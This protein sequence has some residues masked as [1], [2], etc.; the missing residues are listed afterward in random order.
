MHNFQKVIF[1]FAIAGL[2]LA[3]DMI[4]AP[5]TAPNPQS[6]ATIVAGT[7]QAITAA[8]PANT[9][10]TAAT[11]KPATQGTSISFNNVSFV[12]PQGLANGTTNSTTTD[13][14][15]P[16]INPSIGAMPQHI[17]VVFN[18]YSIHGT[19]LDPQIA[20]FK[21][22]EYAQYTDLT[23]QI[24]STLHNL[25]YVQGQPLPQGLPVGPFNAQVK[26]IDFTNGHGL[27]YL[28]QFDE[29]PLPVNNHELIYYYQGLTTDGQ[30][31][32]QVILPLQA[33][34]LPPDENPNSSL[35]ASGI[36]FN[37]DQLQSYFSA[38]TQRLNT[39]TPDQFS[40]PLTALDELIQSIE[41]KP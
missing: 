22:A 34:F 4:P 36:P 6:I 32:V 16:Y 11:S 25:Q 12:I 31:Y 19:L 15:L 23:Q 21:S 14:E 3:C 13:I 37:A 10:Q 20:V 39:T 27:R 2:I 9:S 40:P 38:V 8:A 17:R 18:G 30:Y 1:V 33:P 5:A 29:A 28:T 41:I 7:M 35:P 26:A 24:I